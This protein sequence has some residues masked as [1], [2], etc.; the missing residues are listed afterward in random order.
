MDRR[1]LNLQ[2]QK[3]EFQPYQPE[4]VTW[5][6]KKT[7]YVTVQ[8]KVKIHYYPHPEIVKVPVTS[9]LKRPKIN[10]ELEKDLMAIEDINSH[11]WN[12]YSKLLDLGL[13]EEMQKNK[14]A[15]LREK[16]GEYKFKERK[17]QYIKKYHELY[18]D[19]IS[20]VKTI[21][22]NLKIKT[23]D[24]VGTSYNYHTEMVDTNKSMI[25]E[26]LN[27]INRAVHERRK[28][29]NEKLYH[30]S[31]RNLKA[32]LPESKFDLMPECKSQP[33]KKMIIFDHRRLPVLLDAPLK[34]EGKFKNLGINPS[35][36]PSKNEIKLL[37]EK[38]LNKLEF[39][40]KQNKYKLR[41]ETRLNND[42]NKEFDTVSSLT[43]REK[44]SL[45]NTQQISNI[46]PIPYLDS[47]KLTKKELFSTDLRSSGFGRKLAKKLLN[48]LLASL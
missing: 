21:P 5:V 11:N 40:S 23:V 42:Y 6:E 37:T 31:V 26:K 36:R 8:E 17:R 14:W 38:K 29:R 15:K 20:R 3:R 13:I 12:L 9:I 18:Y 39:R 30:K 48:E 27:S 19:Y 35:Y 33:L 24:Y 41:L 28:K 43:F 25:L 32:N 47:G 7:T 2:R 1:L 44:F 46:Y 4:K 34:K 16:Y 45:H 22:E 10:S